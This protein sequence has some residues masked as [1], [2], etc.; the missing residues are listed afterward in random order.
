M[1]NSFKI[2]CSSIYL[3]LIYSEQEDFGGATVVVQCLPL[4]G[5]CEGKRKALGILGGSYSSTCM[6]WIT[7]SDVQI[8]KVSSDLSSDSTAKFACTTEDSSDIRVGHKHRA[9]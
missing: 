3:R 1:K 6:K 7:D 9:Q 5:Y 2:L 4:T 8:S